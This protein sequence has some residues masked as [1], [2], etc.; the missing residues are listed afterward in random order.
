MTNSELKGTRICKHKGETD[1]ESVNDGG[2]EA[3]HQAIC[4]HHFEKRRGIARRT[5]RNERHILESKLNLLLSLINVSNLYLYFFNS[6]FNRGKF[7]MFSFIA[8]VSQQ[9]HAH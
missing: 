5:N 6:I 3:G 8:W 7:R 4:G 9:L 2:L 1:R